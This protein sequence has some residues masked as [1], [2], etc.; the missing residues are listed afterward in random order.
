MDKNYDKDIIY[1]QHNPFYHSLQNDINQIRE[2]N[3]IIRTEPKQIHNFYSL[4]N[5]LF[6][7]HR[8]YIASDKY[9]EE[10]LNDVQKNIYSNAFLIQ[11]RDNTK[12]NEF[13]RY[14][15]KIIMLLEKLLQIMYK[16]FSEN[17]ILP[18]VMVTK[19]RNPSDAILNR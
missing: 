13:I 6:T 10:K 2:I 11:L 9:V 19:K 3:K 1:A 18:K 16:D 4:I 17:N 12:S 7:N 5:T 15:I 8:H 14:L